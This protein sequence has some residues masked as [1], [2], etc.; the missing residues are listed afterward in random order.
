MIGLLIA[1]AVF[2]YLG[3]KTNKLLNGNQILHIWLFTIA[4]Q[5]L[6]DVFI[7]FKYH[8]Y[9]YFDKELDWRGIIP[10]VFLIPPVN[11]FFLNWFPFKKGWMKQ[12]I[13]L[14]VFVVAIL[15]YEVIT[16]LPEPWGYFHYGWWKL[17]HAAILDPILLLILLGFYKWICKLEK[18]ACLMY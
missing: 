14:T 7:E 10:H 3:F 5:V 9:W 18:K 6:F 11:M 13:Y 2:N 15:I 12:A 8:A 16:L 1:L 4:L 17:W